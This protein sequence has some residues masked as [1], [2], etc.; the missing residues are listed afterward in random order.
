MTKAQAEA[1]NEHAEGWAA[2]LYLA[3]LSLKGGRLVTRL[4]RRRRPLCHGLLEGRGARSRRRRPSSSSCFG[5]LFSTACPARSATRCSSATTR[6][7]CSSS[8]SART[9]SS[10]PSTTGAAGSAT[11]TSSGRCCR[12][13]SSDREPEL[14][15]TLNR[16]AASWCEANGQPELAIEYSAAAGDT[17]ELAR[18][19]TAYAFP[20]Y[21]SGRVTTVERWLAMFDDSAL[22]GRYPAI[23]VFGVWMHACAAG[24]TTPSVGHSPLSPRRPRARCRMEARSRLGPPRSARCSAERASSRC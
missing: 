12:P 5:Q 1:L 21:R 6:R 4:V 16:R 8:W 9:C 24:P 3:A 2:G 10:S 17:D 22:L 20:Y 11:T 7:R 23:A 19:V 15:A 18:L 13:S 14:V